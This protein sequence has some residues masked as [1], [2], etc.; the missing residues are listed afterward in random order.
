MLSFIDF[1]AIVVPGCW[2]GAFVLSFIDFGAMVVGALVTF[3]G[4]SGV[5]PGGLPPMVGA[6][7]FFAAGVGDGVGDEGGLVPGVKT[8]ELG[9]RP[10][11]ESGEE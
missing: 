4:G 6:A 2:L 5:T 3:P 1:G 10:L 8:G 11:G 9:G 7:V